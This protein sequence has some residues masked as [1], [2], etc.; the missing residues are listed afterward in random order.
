MLDS[1]SEREGTVTT[2]AATRVPR[3]MYS[4]PVF[5]PN[6]REDRER[7]G[8]TDGGG[9]VGTSSESWSRL[10]SPRRGANQS[11]SESS[12]VTSTNSSSSEASF[13]SLLA[14]SSSSSTSESG[15]PRASSKIAY[16]QRRSWLPMVRE[17]DCT[18]GCSRKSV[19][20]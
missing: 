3:R 19:G 18:S 7:D 6:C 9:S 12:P 5:G 13:G 8:S 17:T 20:Q 16:P 10:S 2:L 11:S 15:K 14:F 4:V 1:K